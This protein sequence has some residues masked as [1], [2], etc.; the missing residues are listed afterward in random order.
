MKI[1]QILQLAIDEYWLSDKIEY[2][3]TAHTFMC[4]VIEDMARIGLIT[5]EELV[6]VSGHIMKLLG[7]EYT[8]TDYLRRTQRLPHEEAKKAK[9]RLNFWNQVIIDLQAKGE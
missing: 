3:S 4:I 5:H 9:V 1:S 6:A 8:L 2:G 7:K